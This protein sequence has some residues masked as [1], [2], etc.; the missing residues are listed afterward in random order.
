M[1]A[2]RPALHAGVAPPR[3]R[4]LPKGALL[5]AVGGHGRARYAQ[6]AAVRQRALPPVCGARNV[7]RQCGECNRRYSDFGTAGP[8]R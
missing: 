8:P 1:S 3:A 6:G 7:V 4:W 2:G 5:A